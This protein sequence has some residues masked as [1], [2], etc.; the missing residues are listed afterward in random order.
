MLPVQ[1]WAFAA[2]GAKT[3][4][5]IISAFRKKEK[6]AASAASRLAIRTSRPAPLGAPLSCAPGF[7]HSSTFLWTND[8]AVCAIRN[9]RGSLI[10][11][12]LHPI[13]NLCAG[14]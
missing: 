12:V 13:K 14:E 8:C 4:A 11:V 10:F 2:R 7:A 5:V 6:R 9:L 3:A 1:T